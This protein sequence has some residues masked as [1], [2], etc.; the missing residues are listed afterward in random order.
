[1]NRR[2]AILLG[3]MS[4]VHEASK[5]QAYPAKP[6]RFIVPVAAGG[7]SDLVARTVA[8]PLSKALS[9][10][11]IVENIGGGGGIIASQTCA[12]A[13][14]DG[15]TVMLGY[16]GTHGT[17]PAVRKLPYDAIKDFTPIGMIG[18]TPNV[19][20]VSATHAANSLQDFIAQLK[21]SP[22]KSSFGSA[23]PG[24]LTHLV[25]EQLK[26]TTGTF[27]THIPYRG[28]APALTDL[29]GGQIQFMM[30]GLA[31]AL[32]HIKSGRIKALAV[33]GARRHAL[34]PQIPTFNENKLS[35]FEGVQWYGMVGPAKMPA[36][37]VERL[38]TE[39][40]TLIALPQFK[41]RLAAEAIEPMPM[42]AVAFGAYIA[43]DITRWQALVQKRNIQID[44]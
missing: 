7:G 38:N 19:L 41:D 25:C 13:P 30:P 15:Y 28:I 32:P 6:I 23:G 18:G 2:E 11:I 14:A 29:M 43:T 27:A 33:T 5:A 3:M 12:R 20:V 42:S 21:K 37:I 4:M 17:N 16:V 22:G 39:L 31:A 10:P 1:M 24:T 36:S 44:S 8:D 35:E 34:L 40:K 26:Q 9:Q